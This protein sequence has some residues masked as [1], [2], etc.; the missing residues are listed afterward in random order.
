MRP[1]ED[2]IG[3]LIENTILKRRE[4]CLGC[5]YSHG[6]QKH[7]VTCMTN[8]FKVFYFMKSITFMIEN[9]LIEKDEE[10]FLLEFVKTHGTSDD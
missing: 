6:S 8:I 3:L 9:N 7:H 2:L 4:D 1:E 5:Q 10:E